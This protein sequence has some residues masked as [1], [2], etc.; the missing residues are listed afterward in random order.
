MKQTAV[1]WLEV[2]LE[3]ISVDYS[4]SLITF[5]EFLEQYD[6]LLNQ[7]KEREEKTAH[8]Y[9]KFAIRCDRKGMKILNFE[10]WIKL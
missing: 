7:A 5:K 10:D 1:E 2:E 3:S 6:K 9:A 4:C 8:E